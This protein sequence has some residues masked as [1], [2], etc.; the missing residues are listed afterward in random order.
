MLCVPS[1]ATKRKPGLKV[2][3]FLKDFTVQGVLIWYGNV[4]GKQKPSS[5]LASRRAGSLAPSWEGGH[6]C[7]PGIWQTFIQTLRL[8]FSAG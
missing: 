4:V 2:K 3:K 6:L 5:S 8:W 7:L 1:K